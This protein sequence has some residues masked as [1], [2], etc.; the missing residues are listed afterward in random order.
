[1]EE[2]I[3]K[4]EESIESS[5]LKNEGDIADFKRRFLSF[6]K[7]EEGSREMSILRT[8]LHN[9]KDPQEIEM[10]QKVF[11]GIADS[12]VS[13]IRESRKSWKLD[14]QLTIRATP[15]IFNDPPDLTID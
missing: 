4:I 6:S 14:D 15:I 2:L 13:K 7:D 10:L 9:S 5:I 12:M 11:N 1:M 8:K 3:K